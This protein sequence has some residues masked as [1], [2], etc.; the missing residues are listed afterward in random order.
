MAP[1]ESEFDAPA[2]D[3]LQ[4]YSPCKHSSAPSVQTSLCERWSV[5]QTSVISLPRVAT[6]LN[7][8][9]K[10]RR[11]LLIMEFQA[12]EKGLERKGTFV[13]PKSQVIS[14]TDILSLWHTSL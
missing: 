7:K 9:E 5:F 12:T 6:V 3:P 8:E 1:A 13:D 2:L 4:S 10:R 11:N 14:H